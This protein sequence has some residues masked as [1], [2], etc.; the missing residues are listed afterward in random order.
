MMVF[1][2]MA[3]TV[4]TAVVVVM[5]VPGKVHGVMLGKQ[6]TVVSAVLVELDIKAAT[7]VMVVVAAT[8]EIHGIIQ[9]SMLQV[10]TVVLLVLVRLK[11]GQ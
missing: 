1:V 2:E 10:E 4:A 9:G 6:A 11:M 7:A 3:A 8:K 5:A